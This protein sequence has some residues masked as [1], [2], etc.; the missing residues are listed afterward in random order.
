MEWDTTVNSSHA[1]DKTAFVEVAEEAQ[2]IVYALHDARP[3]DSGTMFRNMLRVHISDEFLKCATPGAIAELA[4]E[5]PYGMASRF[6]DTEA[7]FGEETRCI[8]VPYAVY[9]AY[10][11]VRLSPDQKR[12]RDN[13]GALT[14]PLSEVKRLTQHEADAYYFNGGLYIYKGMLFTFTRSLT[15]TADGAVM[16]DARLSHGAYNNFFDPD[17]LGTFLPDVASAG[18]EIVSVK[19]KRF[20]PLPCLTKSLKN[21]VLGFLNEG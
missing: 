14:I 3:I 13:N 9:T 20:Q 12:Y 21:F 18:N 16:M 2:R 10:I 1:N 11:G 15:K 17:S 5:L 7:G 19:D 4:S 8:Y 6:P